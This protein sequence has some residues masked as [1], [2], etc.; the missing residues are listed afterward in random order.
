MEKKNVLCVNFNQDNDLIAMGTKTGFN[1]YMINP[2]SNRDCRNLEGGIGKI[3][4]LNATN[5]IVF[6]GSGDNA[7]FPVNKVI[8]W[9][10]YYGKEMAELRFNSDI[11]NVKLTKTR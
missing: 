2:L 5:L 3:E 9:D 7:Q 6:V 11:K 8:I 10:E 1:I 4:M